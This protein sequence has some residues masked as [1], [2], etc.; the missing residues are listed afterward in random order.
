MTTKQSVAVVSTS[1][2]AAGMA[3]GAVIYSG[4]LNLQQTYTDANYRQAVDINGDGVKDFTFGFE[5]KP[6]SPYI[7]AR[8][9]VS[10]EIPVQSGI[11]GILGKANTGLPVTGP[12]VMIDAAYA[13]TYPVISINRGYMYQDGNSPANTVGDWS[14]TAITDAYVGIELALGSGTNFTNFGWLHFVDDPTSSPVS[15]T[16]KDWAY[17]STPGVGILTPVP[18]PSTCALAGLGIAG[19]LALRNQ[20]QRRS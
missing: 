19:I 5:A 11:V 16:L 14:N 20:R 10:P 2:L 17:E 18:E 13:L 1:A 12:G 7:D 9:Y 6:A 4:P 3:Q 15:L 8:T